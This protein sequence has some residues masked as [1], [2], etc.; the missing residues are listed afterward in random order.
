MPDGERYRSAS[1]KHEWTSVTLLRYPEAGHG[2]MGIAA[3]EKD[4]SIRIFAQMGGT[5]KANISARR[6]SWSK[7][8]LF[9]EQEFSKANSSFD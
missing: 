5:A 9:F 3:D 4:R 1:A 2:V 8:L 7:I 6:D